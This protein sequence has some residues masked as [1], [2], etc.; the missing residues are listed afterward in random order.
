[1]M[2]SNF[3]NRCP[4]LLFCLAIVLAANAGCRQGKM[5][6][7]GVRA[8]WVTRGD[9]R[10]AADIPQIMDN[11]RDGGFNVVLFQ[12]RGNGT[13]FYPSKIEPWAEQFNFR[14]PGFDPLALACREA[15]K[16]GLELHPWV[17]VMP[18]WRGTSPPACPDQLYNKRP[19]WFWY[20]QRGK[21]QP[22][23]SFY[24]SINPCLPEVRRYLVDVFH[25]IVANYPIDG[26]HMDYIRFPSE[27][28]AIPAGSDIDYPRDAKTLALYRQATGL[29]PD[30]DRTA[31]NR[32]RADQVT[33]L[34][35]D[36]REM[37][38]WTRPGSA[39]SAS[40]GAE[41]E[42]SLRYFRDDRRWAKEGLID[43]A[44]PMN[45]QT[46]VARFDSRLSG[47]LPLRSAVT[48]VPG[49]WFAP[50][51]ETDKGIEV[52]RQQI[53]SAYRKTGN[54]CVFSY[55]S[56]FE[57]RDNRDRFGEENRPAGRAAEGRRRREA[58]RKALL[59]VTRLVEARLP[60]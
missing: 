43:A 37:V 18:A 20:D 17:N 56:L 12:V 7:G 2:R 41:Y 57:V 60:A 33:R 34:V 32:W 16:R 23:T 25:E 46:D 40:V 1:M 53:Q 45:Y 10:S 50:S 21:R 11:C 3:D 47:W 9:Y 58:R 55:A 6:T 59:P 42:E 35:A 28:P 8:V 15:H 54:F 5:F 19:E 29:S 44:F 14:S 36:I 49:L 31:W 39:L 51:L 24:V 26:L 4:L 13:V 52:V 30:A 48:V 22:L 38:R 27:P